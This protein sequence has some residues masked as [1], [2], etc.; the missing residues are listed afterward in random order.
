LSAAKIH[1]TDAI[2]EAVKFLLTAYNAVRH[3]ALYRREPHVRLLR[4][5]HCEYLQRGSPTPAAFGLPFAQID[6]ALNDAAI[7]AAVRQ[8]Q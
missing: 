2:S 3:L 6:Q 1:P 8:A 5:A 4:R 7:Q